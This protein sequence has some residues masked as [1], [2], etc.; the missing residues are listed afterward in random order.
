M[1]A[2]IKTAFI[3]T[4][5][6]VKI[7]ETILQKWPT[8]VPK[9]INRLINTSVMWK[10]FDESFHVTTNKLYK[11]IYNATM[12]HAKKLVK[13]LNEDI[14]DNEAAGNNASFPNAEL[15]DH[16]SQVTVTDIAANDKSS[17]IEEEKNSISPK[18]TGK[19]ARFSELVQIATMAD[20]PS[21]D[22]SGGEEEEDF[23][24]QMNG[25]FW[26][27]ILASKN[28]IKSHK[29]AIMKEREWLDA[30]LSKVSM[31]FIEEEENDI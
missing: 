26:K 22:D 4:F 14:S 11:A 18:A 1:R 28:C 16:D 17:A 9:V 23:I 25:A 29:K 30:Q 13:E 27:S 21:D 31:F 10:R 15:K 2:D 24:N 20:Q 6:K 19:R 7:D 3:N 5:H 12:N 8:F